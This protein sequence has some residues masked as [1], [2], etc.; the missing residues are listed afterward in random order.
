MRKSVKSERKKL[1]AKLDAVFSEYIR[2]R[3]GY[4]CITCGVQG[5][6]RDGLMQCGHLFTRAS[7]STRWDELNCFCQCRGCNLSHE[8]DPAPFTIRFIHKY[9][10]EAYERLYAKSKSTLKLTDADMEILIGLYRH[11]KADMCN[12]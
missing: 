5:R 2:A 6:E 11:K 9:G 7:Y 12:G 1:V 10:Q 4:R 3:D 8:Y